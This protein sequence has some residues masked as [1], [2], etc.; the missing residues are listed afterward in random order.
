MIRISFW[1]SG[2]ERA[3]VK[4]TEIFTA[5]SSGIVNLFVVY[6]PGGIYYMTPT[7]GVS[8]SVGRMPR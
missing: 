1:G 8:A 7:D 3:N 5:A 6:T 2:L 4:N